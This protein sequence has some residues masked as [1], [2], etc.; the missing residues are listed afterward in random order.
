MALLAAVL[1]T[2][3]AVLW[4]VDRRLDALAVRL[5]VGFNAATS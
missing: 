1:L 3:D 2:P 4:T 5:G